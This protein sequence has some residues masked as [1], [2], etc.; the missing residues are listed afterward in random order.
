M[1]L[2]YCDIAYSFYG[3]T[4]RT[5]AQRTFVSYKMMLSFPMLSQR[6]IKNSQI[7]TLWTRIGNLWCF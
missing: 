1:Q 2:S 7:F 3:T 5:K 4:Y 6:R